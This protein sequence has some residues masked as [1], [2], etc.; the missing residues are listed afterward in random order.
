VSAAAAATVIAIVATVVTTVIATVVDEQQD[1]DNEQQPGA[2]RLAAKEITQTHGQFPPFPKPQG[3]SLLSFHP[4]PLRSMSERKMKYR[5]FVR[6]QEIIGD[7][8]EKRRT[9]N[10]V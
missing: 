9:S 7:I 10:R 2:V 1:H 5:D 4:M 3:Q 6:K 8:F